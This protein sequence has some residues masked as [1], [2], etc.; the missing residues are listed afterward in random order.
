[1]TPKDYLIGLLS[2]IIFVFIMIMIDMNNKLKNYQNIESPTD[3]LSIY[4]PTNILLVDFKN[5]QV[6][7]ETNDQII[8]FTSYTK[9][10]DYVETLTANQSDYSNIVFDVMKNSWVENISNDTIEMVT[11]FSINGGEYHNF[12]TKKDIFKEV[13]YVNTNYFTN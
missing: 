9:M 10:F 11:K 8:K 7:Q 4:T 3:T 2:A 12:F 13:E 5:L 6:I 1:M